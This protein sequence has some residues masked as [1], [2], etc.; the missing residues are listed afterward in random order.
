MVA[1]SQNVKRIRFQALLAILLILFVVVPY[2]E[3]NV[4]ADIVL[5]ILFISALFI[6]GEKSNLAFVSYAI[7]IAA[8]AS[9]WAS[10]WR[11]S[12]QLEVIANLFEIAFTGIVIVAILR[13][14]FHAITITRET[15][16]GA[17]CVYLFIG[18]MWANVY[19]LQDIAQ[20]Q[21]FSNITTIEQHSNPHFRA[22]QFTY[23][24]FVTLSTL[25][26]G[27][28]TPQTHQAKALAAMEAIL[29][30]LYL[31]VL[32]ARLVGQQVSH[33]EDEQKN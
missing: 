9:S 3:I 23:F 19:T 17:I 20:P 29:G 32:I 13:Q 14:V 33:R 18:L 10:Y 11:S 27:D 7:C 12:T 25:G 5:T 15:I 28:I 24:S 31:A 2:F 4:F 26:Y 22:A 30:Q 1:L 8:L 21:S 6:F 16:A